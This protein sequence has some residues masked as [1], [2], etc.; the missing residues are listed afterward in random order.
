MDYSVK[1]DR[2]Q[3]TEN[4]SEISSSCELTHLNG[5]KLEEVVQCDEAQEDGDVVC[6]PGGGAEIRVGGVIAF[7]S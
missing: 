5:A 6:E 3:T 2:I 7:R 4:R 1:S